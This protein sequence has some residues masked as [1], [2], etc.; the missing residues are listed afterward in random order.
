MLPPRAI[1]P[2]CGPV[3][4][5]V[6]GPSAAIST[7]SN[8]PAP[9]SAVPPSDP[10]GAKTNVSLLSA[11]PARFSKP[12]KVTV[13]SVPLPDPLTCQ[14]LSAA[15]PLS[16]SV[17]SPPSRLT[18]VETVPVEPEDGGDP[19]AAVDAEPVMLL[20]PCVATEASEPLVEA[21]ALT[22]VGSPVAGALTGLVSPL[23]GAELADVA[24]EAVELSAGAARS[25]A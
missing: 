3:M 2:D 10:P 11:A 1:V 8:P 25:S 13:P 9:P 6:T 24:L 23:D 14:V 17:P 21:A 19:D 20:P 12:A 7:V 18:G 22:C 4:V 5:D 15:G 16:V